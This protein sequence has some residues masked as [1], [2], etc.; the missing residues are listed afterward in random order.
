LL[1][2]DSPFPFLLPSRIVTK[3]TYDFGASASGPPHCKWDGE[4]RA[5]EGDAISLV[6]FRSLLI[7]V[8]GVFST[9]GGSERGRPIP[10][11]SSSTSKDPP[12]IVGA[13]RERGFRAGSCQGPADLA[14]VARMG[15]ARAK[16]LFVA[17]P[18]FLPRPGPTS[19]SSSSSSSSSPTVIPDEGNERGGEGEPTYRLSDS[20]PKSSRPHS[21]PS[22]C[23]ERRA[24]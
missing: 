23:G 5:G 7:E 12:P 8:N 17:E 2:R 6:S 14:P 3:S 21:L 20:R 4:R 15:P 24:S 22:T 19:S 9:A 11:L 13:W 18:A 10:L 16:A 1:L